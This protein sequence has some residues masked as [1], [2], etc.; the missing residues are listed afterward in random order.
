MFS[1]WA[2]AIPD[3]ENEEL[4]ITGG[5]YTSTLVSVYSEDGW[6]RNLAPLVE[7]R[8]SHACSSFIFNEVKV[9]HD[10]MNIRLIST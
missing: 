1:R 4:I 8:D 2:C 5:V 6:Q 9:I 3:Q 10:T 7:G